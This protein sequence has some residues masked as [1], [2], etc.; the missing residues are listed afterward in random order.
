MNLASTI[1]K[2]SFSSSAASK[3]N[4][5]SSKM[6]VT[7]TP[8]EDPVKDIAV[9]TSISTS[10]SSSSGESRRNGDTTGIYYSEPA[11]RTTNSAGE[12]AGGSDS[13]CHGEYTTAAD[14]AA[15]NSGI[16]LKP[17]LTG[18]G[19]QKEGEDEGNGAG[20]QGAA[21]EGASPWHTV[22]LSLSVYW[23]VMVVAV[24]GIR[25]HLRRT[26]GLFLRRMKTFC[27][28]GFVIFALKMTRMQTRVSC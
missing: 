20:T 2:I 25:E 17:E 9:S 5:S 13:R 12:L 6:A 22:K 16:I 28:A 1:R 14:T 11:C 3:A 26:E 27:L 15:A 24:F 19:K 4:T 8:V 10:S 23:M 18:A 21:G 7:S